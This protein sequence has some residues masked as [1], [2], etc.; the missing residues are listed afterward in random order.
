MAAPGYGYG[1]APGKQFYE[2]PGQDGAY[3]AEKA[4]AGMGYPAPKGASDWQQQGGYDRYAPVVQQPQPQPR[5]FSAEAGGG[6]ADPYRYPAYATPAQPSPQASYGQ[7][8]PYGPPPSGYQQ[9]PQQYAQQQGAAAPE[10]PAYQPPYAQQ[11]TPQGAHQAPPA[12]P[13]EYPY[14]GHSGPQK[15]G[16]PQQHQ[17]QQH[18]QPQPSPMQQQQQQPFAYNRPQAH[19]PPQQPQQQPGQV[20][21]PPAGQVQYPQPGQQPYAPPEYSNIGQA[22]RDLNSEDETFKGIV[23]A[24][25]TYFS[26]EYDKMQKNMVTTTA[27]MKSRMKEIDERLVSIAATEAALKK[28]KETLALERKQVEAN[29]KTYERDVT[30]MVGEK[31][32]MSALLSDLGGVLMRVEKKTAPPAAPAPQEAPA[33]APRASKPEFEESGNNAP[34]PTARGRGDPRANI[35]PYQTDGQQGFCHT[36]TPYHAKPRHTR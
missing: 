26:K 9:P 36:N 19:Q 4:E 17:Q 31:E 28:E 22:V 8:S 5:Q 32:K 25:V 34:R 29:V 16:P 6:P 24:C 13:Q 30:N 3:G 33:S 1:Q 21:P 23:K 7:K 15:A 14:Y 35:G 2:A 12:S 27:N 20:P 10:Q 11:A 18:Q